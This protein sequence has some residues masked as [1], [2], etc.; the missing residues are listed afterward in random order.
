MAPFCLLLHGRASPP[1]FS[2]LS[3]S[4][5]EIPVEH[6]R[7]VLGIVSEQPIINTF[8]S[9][10]TVIS[11][12]ILRL[13]T[14]LSLLLVQ[15][16]DALKFTGVERFAPSL[17]DNGESYRDRF[18]LPELSIFRGPHSEGGFL[19][20]RKMADFL[21]HKICQS[22]VLKRLCVPPPK[23]FRVGEASHP[24]PPLMITIANVTSIHE[25][26]CDLIDL[27]GSGIHCLAET[28][29]TASTVKNNMPLARSLSCTMANQSRLLLQPR[30]G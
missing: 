15:Q 27:W 7:R 10:S 3:C 14:F 24:G 11:P 20:G 25:R 12:G 16:V 6:K 26:T 19:W 22:F 4:H 29:A 9:S 5:V 17:C 1:S 21:P 8:R 23:I 28:S 13:V 30:K 2:L 18:P